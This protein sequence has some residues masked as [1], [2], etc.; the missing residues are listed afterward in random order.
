M[1]A[2]LAT[3]L[4]GCSSFGTP[5]PV[6]QVDPNAFPANYRKQIATYLQTYL[7]DRADFRSSL[8]AEPAMKPVEQSQHYVVCVQF[9]GHNQ[10]KTKAAIYLAGAITQFVDPKP[11]QCDDAVYQP[12]QELADETPEK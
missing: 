6:P 10:H 2:L 9:N 12:F 7:V 4:P 3:V 11:G 1:A 8:I 5:K